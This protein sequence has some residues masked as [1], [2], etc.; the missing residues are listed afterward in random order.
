M[1]D[2]LDTCGGVKVTV[3]GKLLSCRDVGGVPVEKKRKCG[4]DDFGEYGGV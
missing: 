4:V 1:Y 2:R 3:R